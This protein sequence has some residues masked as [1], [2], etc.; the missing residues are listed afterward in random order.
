MKFPLIALLLPLPFTALAA[1]SFDCA[2]ASGEVEQLICKDATLARLD[3]QL[4][5]LWPK[6]IK[7]MSDEEK[8]QEKAMQRGWIKGRNECWKGSDMRACVEQNY[9]TRIT[10]LQIKGGQVMVPAPVGYR[11]GD[12]RLTV[13]FYNE[14]AQSAAVI[15]LSDKGAA[16][17]QLLAFNVRTASGAKYEGQNLSLWT[18]GKEALL[19]RY[20]QPDSQCQEITVSAE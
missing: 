17:Q 16:P 15:N 11:C 5:A 6:A 14:T 18:K 3:N 12:T 4:S 1:P 10:E 19:E 2:K 20:G 13:Y 8:K 7:G 9:L